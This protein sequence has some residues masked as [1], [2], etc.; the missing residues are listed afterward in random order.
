MPP[1][2]P[3]PQVLPVLAP[4]PQCDV[5]TDPSP[6]PVH[7]AGRRGQGSRGRAKGKGVRGAHVQTSVAADM[8]DNVGVGDAP[9]LNESAR[10]TRKSTR[11][12]K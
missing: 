2:L 1:S 8:D 12:Q 4:P 10:P 6:E 5:L 9:P 7:A 3:A 11:I